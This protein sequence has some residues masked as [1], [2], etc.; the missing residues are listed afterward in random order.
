MKLI[1]CSDIQGMY[2]QLTGGVHLSCIYVHCAISAR[3]AKFGVAV[4]KAS[5]FF[6]GEGSASRSDY[7]CQVWCSGMEGTYAQLQ[8][9]NV[10]WVYVHCAIHETYLVSGFC[11]DL[12]SIGGEWGVNLP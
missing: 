9:V 12:C 3:A 1:W 2:V 6:E 7:I 10:P 11:R 8:G 5:I 4:F